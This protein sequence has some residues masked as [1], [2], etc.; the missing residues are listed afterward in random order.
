MNSRKFKEETMKAD[1]FTSYAQNFEDVLLWRAFKNVD[2]GFYIDVGAGDPDCDSVT[3]SFYKKGWRGINLEP[4]SARFKKFE[5][6]RLRDI[7]IQATVGQKSGGVSLYDFPQSTYS[8][9]DQTLAKRIEKDRGCKCITQKVDV[10]SLTKIC[11]TYHCSPIH[12][13]RLNLQALMDISFEEIDLSKIRPWVIV[14]QSLDSVH[15]GK[16]SDHLDDTLA[17]EDYEFVYFDG[18]NRY[19]VAEEKQKIKKYFMTPPNPSDSF[20]LSG[21]QSFCQEQV[22][23]NKGE[24]QGDVMSVR[25]NTLQIEMSVLRQNLEQVLV[26]M[27]ETRLQNQ[28]LIFRNDEIQTQLHQERSVVAEQNNLVHHKDNQIDQLQHELEGVKI[29]LAETLETNHNWWVTSCEYKQEIERIKKSYSWRI[30]APLR[31]LKNLKTLPTRVK[32]GIFSYQGSGTRWILGYF[33]QIFRWLMRFSFVRF[34]LRSWLDR[35][36]VLKDRLRNFMKLSASSPA[37]LESQTSSFESQNAAMLSTNVD[38][39]KMTASAKR[40]LKNFKAV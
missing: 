13:L 24:E 34:R 10:K 35:R 40:L 11:E 30:T 31:F 22:S 17:A 36:S 15:A 38:L 32:E 7:N 5:A 37:Q 19:Y 29:H 4:T 3:K 9:F 39:S 25:V 21:T 33:L 16:V 12:F 18:L 20:R 1:I 6:S 28:Q 8:T 26:K 23:P 27:S 2:K 14:I